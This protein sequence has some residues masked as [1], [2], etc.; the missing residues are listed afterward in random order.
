MRLGM[1]IRNSGPVSTPEFISAC[2]QAAEAQG[3]DDVYV[4]DHIA[5]PPDDAE[6]SGGRYVDPL[7]T[8]AFVAGITE[9]IG[10]GISVLVLPYRTALPTAKWIASIQ[11]L[12]GGRLVLG[13]GPGWMEAEFK[14]AGVERRQRGRITDDLLA[15]LHDCFANDVVTRNEQAFIFSPRPARPPILVGGNGPHVVRRIVA[16]GD[17]WMPT[18]GDP[19]VLKP[20]IAELAAALVAAGKP[21]PQVVPL[22]ALPLEEPA[23]A[24]ARLEAL[25]EAGCT[26]IECP[27]RYASIDEFKRLADALVAAKSD[28]GL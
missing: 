19:A 7:A 18:E 14:A 10:L 11:E 8:L 20:A 5:I 13:V 12:S 24:A 4:L 23:T 28:A 27:A 21:A 25:A 3:L 15:F 16:Y 9:R 1:L 6:G 22:A 17:G 2:A 26:G